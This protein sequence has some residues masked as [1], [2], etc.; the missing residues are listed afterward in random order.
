MFRLPALAL[1]AFCVSGLS[2]L[3][4]AERIKAVNAVLKCETREWDHLPGASSLKKLSR[5]V[6]VL[7]KKINI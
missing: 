7:Q 1:G 6:V 4:I 5:D 3:E 2:D